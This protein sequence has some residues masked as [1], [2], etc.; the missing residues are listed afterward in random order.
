M[1]KLILRFEDAMLKEYDMELTVTI[2]RLA[3]NSVRQ[4]Q[5]ISANFSKRTAASLSSYQRPS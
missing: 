1:P 3:D 4:Q 2:G 5:V